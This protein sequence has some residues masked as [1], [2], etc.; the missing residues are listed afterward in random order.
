MT[1]DGFLMITIT[2]CGVIVRGVDCCIIGRPCHVIVC[3]AFVSLR[4]RSLTFFSLGV[5]AKRVGRAATFFS[6]FRSPVYL[7]SMEVFTTGTRVLTVV[8]LTAY[9]FVF[10]L[11]P[12]ALIC[13][14]RPLNLF[15]R[16]LGV[17]GRLVMFL[18]ARGFGRG[19]RSF[20]SW[21][22]APLLSFMV[23]AVS[24]SGVLSNDS[25]VRLGITSGPSGTALGTFINLGI[26]VYFPG[27]VLGRLLSVGP[28][29]SR[30]SL[31]RL[32]FVS[33]NVS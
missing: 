11:F 29:V 2:F 32:I 7:M 23:L 30:D 31:L 20:A 6:F 5:L 14:F 8:R 26:S 22:E 15:L 9:L 21:A 16:F 4:S 27:I 33:T 19:G 1:G 25:P 3:S 28:W 10:R 13:P 12:G 18:F 17:F 24:M